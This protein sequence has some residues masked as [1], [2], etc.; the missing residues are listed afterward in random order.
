V[1][2]G[3]KRQGATHSDL[4]EIGKALVMPCVERWGVRSNA[5]YAAKQKA[6]AK[7]T[8]KKINK[9]AQAVAT[10]VKDVRK[11]NGKRGGR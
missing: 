11:Q 3:A 7:K 4:V 10:V 2:I 8:E 9:A 5:E 1:L 6:E